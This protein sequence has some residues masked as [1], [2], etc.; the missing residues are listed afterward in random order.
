MLTIP[1]VV[2]ELEMLRLNAAAGSVVASPELLFASHDL[3]Q[4]I[5]LHGCHMHQ[6]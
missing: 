6:D 3:L 1:D 5:V 2:P 4:S